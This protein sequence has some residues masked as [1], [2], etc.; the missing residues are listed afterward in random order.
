MYTPPLVRPSFYDVATRFAKLYVSYRG[1]YVESSKG[2]YYVPRKTYMDKSYDVRL[3]DEIITAHLN[4]QYAIAIFAGPFSSKF[5]CFDVD[6]PDKEVVRKLVDALVDFGFP[7]EKIYVSSSGGKGYHVEMFFSDLTYTKHL[8]NTYE[9][10]CTKCGFDKHKVEFRPTENQAI[11]LPLSV[12]CKT[13]KVCWYLDQE[14]LEPIEDISYVMHI[15]QIDRDWAHDLMRKRARENRKVIPLGE[16]I[17]QEEPKEYPAG[18][19]VQTIRCAEKLPMLV[20]PGTRHDTMKTIAVNERYRGASQETIVDI[21]T[22]WIDA[23]NHAF[24]TSSREEVL[25]DAEQLAAYV[26]SPKFTSFGQN[27]YF[28][29]FDIRN[30][31]SVSGR[32]QRRVLFTVIAFCK[33]H[34]GCARISAERIGR[35]VG[36]S[37]QGVSKSIKILEEKDLFFHMRGERMVKGDDYVVFPNQYYYDPPKGFVEQ[38]IPLDWDFKEESF[39][40][41]YLGLL[42]RA[43]PADEWD[44]YFT[45]KELEELRN[46]G[47]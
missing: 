23:Q 10:I 9:I 8:R 40:E 25:K 18:E 12:H 47:N 11:K 15:Q 27:V 20:A 35:Y 33:R 42:R 6:I 7:R 2:R 24:Y 32:V 14:T 29:E 45:K 46:D 39:S 3:T 36:T 38:H 30:L 34:H 43:V 16:H 26:W 1:R 5:V 41:A 28:N 22:E 19:H 31:L 37:Q 17:K 4:R 13:G 21:L 44:I